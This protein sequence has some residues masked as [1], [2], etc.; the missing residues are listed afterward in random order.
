MEGIRIPENFDL[1]TDF[2]SVETNRA[3]LC[4]EFIYDKLIN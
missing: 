1:K 3:K 4:C 2:N